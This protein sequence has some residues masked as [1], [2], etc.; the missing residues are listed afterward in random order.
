MKKGLEVILD[1]ALKIHP[2]LPQIIEIGLELSPYL[3]SAWQSYKMYRL[4]NRVQEH[5]EQ[6]ERISVL[7]SNTSLS[8]KYIQER[9]A[10]IVLS[11]LIE[12]HEDAKINYILHGFENVFINEKENESLVIN[13]FDTLRNLRYEDVKRFFY[14]IDE[15]ISE[16]IHSNGSEEQALQRS[17]DGKLKNLGLLKIKA[18]WGGFEG[19]DINNTR[20]DA[21]LTLYGEKFADFISTYKSINN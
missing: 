17:I 20:E 16:P 5:S 12:E 6:L 3:G 4:E 14:F 9:I 13:Y 11:D 21:R 2:A 1:T 18:K 8:E 7:Y 10:P 19:H 15:M